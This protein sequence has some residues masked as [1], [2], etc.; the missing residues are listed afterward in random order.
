M[1]KTERTP[2]PPASLA[3]EKEKANGSYEKD[4]V[5]AQLTADFAEKCYLCE[6]NELE[7]I[8]IEHLRPH[9]GG[10]D[11][12]LKFSWDNLFFSCAHC[13]QVKNRSKYESNIID[14]CSTEPEAAIHQAL[15]G[16][17]VVVVP[18]LDTPEAINTADLV[19][20]CF[21]L[22]NTAIRTQQ[23]Q[24][25]VRALMRT[26]NVLYKKLEELEQGS[27][28]HVLPALRG[29]LSRKYKFAGFTR[30]YVRDHLD[31]YPELEP[32]VRLDP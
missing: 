5:V 28:K 13:N 29:M 6:Q 19:Q 20:D 4:D 32:Y 14:C 21:E 10:K 22:R 31:K 16:G 27:G 9:H 15:I 11:K 12:N 25:K 24:N 30:T 2:T 8:H 3:I 7:S 26:M 17:H 23:S 1:V 18:L